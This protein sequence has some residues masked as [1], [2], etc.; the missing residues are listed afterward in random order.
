MKTLEHNG[1][2]FPPDYE[3]HDV[4]VI[5]NGKKIVLDEKAEEYATIYAKYIESLTEVDVAIKKIKILF[6]ENTDKLLKVKSPTLNDVNILKEM[7]NAIEN[8]KT[9][10]LPKVKSTRRFSSVEKIM[11]KYEKDLEKV[12]AYFESKA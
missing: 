2:L 7:N 8:F 5:Y 10:I 9:N 3:K 6:D 1:V 11:N 4:P 12:T